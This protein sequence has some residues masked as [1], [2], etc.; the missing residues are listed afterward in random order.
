M[1]ERGT[2]PASDEAALRRMRLQRRAGTKP[3]VRLRKALHARGMR[4]RV[5]APLPLPGL[6]RRADLLF[7]KARVAVFV[8]GCYWHSCPEH[9]TKPKANAPWWSQKLAANVARDRETDQRLVAAGWLPVRVWEHEANGA[10]DAAAD[11][12]E[13]IIRERREHGTSPGRGPQ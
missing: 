3:E 4:Y 1:A 11:R 2:P 6:R 10:V 5:D 9:G 8:D 12:L 7:P 13:A